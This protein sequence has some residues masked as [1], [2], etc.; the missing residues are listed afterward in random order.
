MNEQKHADNINPKKDVS[1]KSSKVIGGSGFLS[2]DGD[3]RIAGLFN[4]NITVKG[5]LSIETGA[6]VNGSVNCISLYLSGGYSG[7]AV[8]TKKCVLL[9]GSV[10]SG[11]LISNDVDYED[12]CVFNAVHKPYHV[13]SDQSTSSET[14]AEKEVEEK[15]RASLLNELLK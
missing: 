8:V 13:S 15:P 10:F 4:G 11:Q 7:H 14:P 5:S 2:F 3:L 6:Q 12:G 1:S 9:N